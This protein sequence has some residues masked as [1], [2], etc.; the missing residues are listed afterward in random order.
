MEFTS[1]RKVLFYLYYPLNRVVLNLNLWFRVFLRVF[2]GGRG[3]GRA[4]REEDSAP[5]FAVEQG[6]LRQEPSRRH[7]QD[8]LQMEPKKSLE[9]LPDWTRNRRSPIGGAPAPPQSEVG[10]WFGFSHHTKKGSPA[11]PEIL[12]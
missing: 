5:V 12:Q 9:I 11:E 10:Y 6:R 8:T 3:C 7:S 4:Y 1:L 2:T